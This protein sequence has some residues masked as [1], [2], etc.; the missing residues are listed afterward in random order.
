[1]PIAPDNHG[2]LQQ[3]K[4]VAV[5]NPTASAAPPAKNGGV[6]IAVRKWTSVDA[7]AHK[8]L[9]AL[10]SVSNGIGHFK[11]P[12]GSTFDYPLNKLFVLPRYGLTAMMIGC[13]L[14]LAAYLVAIPDR[15]RSR[16]G[17]LTAAVLLITAVWMAS[18]VLIWLSLMGRGV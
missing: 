13:A 15:F 14:V 12:D 17:P 4:G 2:V 18:V 5:T 7:N 10:V 16:S 6:L 3:P 1:M 9:A 8:I 11:R